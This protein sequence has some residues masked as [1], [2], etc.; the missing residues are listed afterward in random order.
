[1]FGAIDRSFGV[2]Q[3]NVV[4]DFQ[5]QMIVCSCRV[6]TDKDFATTLASEAP[7]CPRSALEAYRCLGCGPEC[8]RCLKTVR[9]LLEDARAAGACEGCPVDCA[10]REA[11]DHAEVRLEAAE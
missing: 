4:C 2:E 5:V 8:G 6:F 7:G 3:S 11:H 9:R 10:L 1:L